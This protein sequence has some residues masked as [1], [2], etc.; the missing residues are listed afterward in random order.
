MPR[1]MNLAAVK[2]ALASP[3]TPAGLKKGL[4]KKYGHLLGGYKPTIGA[5]ATTVRTN[6]KKAK[7]KKEKFDIIAYSEGGRYFVVYP[8]K[9]YIG[10]F[11][12]EAKMRAFLKPAIA[13]GFTVDDKMV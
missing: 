13:S 1:T 10:A 8:A 5:L 12:T 4:M 3:K 7:V 2:G 9:K 6:P 11:K